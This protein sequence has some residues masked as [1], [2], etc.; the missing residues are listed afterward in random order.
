MSTIY[1]TFL[2]PPIRHL[3]SLS[4]PSL[5]CYMEREKGEGLLYVFFLSLRPIS[6]RQHA[7]FVQVLL[8]FLIWFADESIFQ[9]MA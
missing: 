9:K 3:P 7:T 4:F 1:P 2:L 8:P 6:V 5:S